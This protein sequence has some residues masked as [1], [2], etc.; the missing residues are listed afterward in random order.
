M[1]QVALEPFHLASNNS[2]LTQTKS[3]GESPVCW[4]GYSPGREAPGS[5]IQVRAAKWNSINWEGLEILN[6][7]WLGGSSCVGGTSLNPLGEGGEFNSGLLK[8]KG[9]F[10]SPPY[11]YG[12]GMALLQLLGTEVDIWLGF[13]KSGIF[14]YIETFCREQKLKMWCLVL[15][16]VGSFF[17]F[18]LSPLPP[19]PNQMKTTTKHKNP[20]TKPKPKQKNKTCVRAF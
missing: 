7:A 19:N 1:I 20:H 12:D 4:L 2:K 16:S 18:L 9:K 11:S 3:Q 5:Q 15:L 13:L 8:P 6:D 10:L 14:L 17:I